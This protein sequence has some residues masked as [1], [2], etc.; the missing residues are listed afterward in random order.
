[1]EGS[2][3]RR[4]IQDVAPV[5]DSWWFS[6]HPP[7]M[8]LL[9]NIAEGIIELI[10]CVKALAGNERS[11]R[12]W[13]EVVACFDYARNVSQNSKPPNANCKAV[14][15]RS[16]TAKKERSELIATDFDQSKNMEVVIEEIERAGIGD[17][18]TE[19]REDAAGNKDV[20]RPIIKFAPVIYRLP[21]GTMQELNARLLRA[22]ADGMGAMAS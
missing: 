14:R 1:M 17:A 5:D 18:M 2:L 15:S 11:K 13:D 4:L 9:Q 10:R 8:N 3:N 12:G 21:D 22:T 7:T 19:N 6:E 16:P 20:Y